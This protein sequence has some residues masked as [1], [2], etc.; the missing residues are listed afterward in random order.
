MADASA[1]LQALLSTKAALDLGL[2][3]PADYDAVKRAFLAAQQ[4]RAAVDAGLVAEGDYEAT[5]ARYLAELL[6]QGGGL[7]GGGSAAAAAAAPAANGAPRA[8]APPPPPAAAAAPPP[9]APPAPRAPPPAPQPPPQQQQPQP[10]PAAPPPPPPPP[11]AAGV[12]ANLPR[13]GG[14]KPVGAGTSM[15]GIRLTEDAVNL[16]YLIRSKSAY[17]WATWRVDDSG[18]AVVIAA[19]GAP[20]APYADFLAALPEDDCRYGGERDWV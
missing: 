3:T 15:S 11:P 20:G 8:P 6:A 5:K 2:V 7:G 10:Q 14:A 12:P 4:I 18:A 16:F 19:V 13:V 9:P 1:S 17:Q